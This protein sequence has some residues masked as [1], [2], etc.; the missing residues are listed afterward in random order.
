MDFIRGQAPLPPGVSSRLEVQGLPISKPPYGIIAAIDMDKGAVKWKI[1]HGETP[2][3]VSNHPALKGRDLPRTGR[4]GYAGTLVTRTLLIAGETSFGP[5]PGSRRGAMLRAYDKATGAE[6]GA[7]YMTAP[8][9]GSPMTYMVDGRQY[10]VV[11]I[12]G[13]G[14]PGELVAYRVPASQLQ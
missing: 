10:L 2:E 11:A 5:T 14:H 4:P 13:A 7:V 6:V 12:S 1:A 3:A 9:E 8:Q